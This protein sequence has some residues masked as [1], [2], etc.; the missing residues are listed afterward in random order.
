MEDVKAGF[1]KKL[2]KTYSMHQGGP[3]QMT[4]R[5]GIHKKYHE[6]VDNQRGQ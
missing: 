5:T 3:A 6:L 1:E 2:Y 4:G